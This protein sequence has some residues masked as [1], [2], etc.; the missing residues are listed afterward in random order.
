MERVKEFLR[1]KGLYVALGTGVLAFM[2]LMIAYNYNTFKKDLGMD[3]QTIDLNA[4][5]TQQDTVQSTQQAI[6]AQIELPEVTEANSNDVVAGTTDAEDNKEETAD[7]ET[8]KEPNQEQG[9]TTEEMAT[10]EEMDEQDALAA[11]TDPVI[12]DENGVMVAKCYDG[13]SPLV[14]PVEGEVILPYSMDTTIF[15]KTLSCYRCNP[16]MLIA[17]DEGANVMTAY[18]GVVDSITEDKEHGTMVTVD[19]GNGYKAIYGQLMNVTVSE[20]EPVTTAQ[21]IGEV[22]PVSSYYEKEGNHLYFELQ[23]DGVAVN[24]TI[25]MQ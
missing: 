23:K 25:Y 20:N 15:F 2:G 18:E 7:G 3:Q 17:G 24:P 19:M 21:N 10:T 12:V 8:S 13:E 9:D 16:G 11:S 4:P 14:W 6:Q 22:A 1:T 5:D